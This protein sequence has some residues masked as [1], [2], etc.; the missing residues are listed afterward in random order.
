MFQKDYIL[1]QIDIL[2]RVIA[3]VISLRK[4]GRLEEA[5]TEI[6]QALGTVWN[7][8]RD[9]LI[10]LSKAD[11]AA[12]CYVNDSLNGELAVA[13]ADLLIQDGEMFELQEV[14]GSAKASYTQALVLYEL[15]VT[16]SSTLPLNAYDRID[17]LKHAI[18]D[19]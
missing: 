12:L 16:E 11:L 2:V 17:Q 7:L 8:H 4:E 1:R 18:E 6:V 9:D 13:L 19:L 3:Y 10:T 5:Q 14:P 15:I